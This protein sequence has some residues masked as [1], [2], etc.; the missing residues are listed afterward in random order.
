MGIALISEKNSLCKDLEG[1]QKK[2]IA[3]V[4]HFS[5]TLTL[6]IK[7]RCSSQKILS[8]T[9]TLIHEYKLY[10]FYYIL[11]D[12]VY[13][14]ISYVGEMGTSL[15]M[16]IQ[17]ILVMFSQQPESNPSLLSDAVQIDNHA[18]MHFPHKNDPLL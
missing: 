18:H 6:G 4:S 17:S 8:L 16:Y 10:H 13:K 11:E 1:P 14:P 12:I 9:N 15:Q 2:F 7:I 5:S 3:F